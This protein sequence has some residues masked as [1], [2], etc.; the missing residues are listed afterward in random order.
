MPQC[1]QSLEKRGPGPA[2][3]FFQGREEWERVGGG[4]RG[5]VGGRQK[6]DQLASLQ[7][8]GEKERLAQQSPPRA[9][10]SAGAVPLETPGLAY[11]AGE[12]PGRAGGAHLLR[13]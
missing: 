5:V 2:A 3:E 11:P 9:H 8:R 6:L 4:G 12:T 10:L 1:A 7:M 13:G